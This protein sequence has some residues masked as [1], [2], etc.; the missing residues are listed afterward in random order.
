MRPTRPTGGAKIGQCQFPLDETATCSP[1][2]QRKS[3]TRRCTTVAAIRLVACSCGTTSFTHRVGRTTV[4]TA[5]L[6]TQHQRQ[7]GEL[8][9]VHEVGRNPTTSIRRR[10]SAEEGLVHRVQTHCTRTRAAR[11]SPRTSEFG[12]KLAPRATSRSTSARPTRFQQRCRHRHHRHGRISSCIAYA[13]LPEPI[14]IIS[15]E[16][17]C[18]RPA[19]MCPRRSGIQHP[20][21]VVRRLRPQLGARLQLY[22]RCGAAAAEGHHPAHHRLHGHTSGNKNVPDPRN[23]SGSGN[24]SITN[25]FI[26]LGNRVYMTEEQFQDEMRARCGGQPGK[27]IIWAARSAVSSRSEPLRDRRRIN[28]SRLNA[29]FSSNAP[30]A[31]RLSVHWWISST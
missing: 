16:P 10:P 14:K 13:V 8:A 31:L 29:S 18:T 26:D 23:W 5:E 2:D 11:T 7:R 1:S 9:E 15:F 20:D 25:M 17:T 19:R 12:Y 27:D 28:S 24:R 3:T 30:G 6:D 22:R 21:A 4:D